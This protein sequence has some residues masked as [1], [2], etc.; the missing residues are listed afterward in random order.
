M[1]Q[2][3][4]CKINLKLNNKEYYQDN[5]NSEYI[6]R[7]DKTKKYDENDFKLYEGDLLATF[8]SRKDITSEFFNF[9][10][11]KQAISFNIKPVAENYYENDGSM[12]N[13]KVRAYE[14]ENPQKDVL[15]YDYEIDYIK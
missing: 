8:T 1:I 14:E 12:I 10:N 5:D 13:I 2:R 7:N 11:K 4:G 15:L 6:F 9:E 3:R